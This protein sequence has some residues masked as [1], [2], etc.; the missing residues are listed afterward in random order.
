MTISTSFGVLAR[1]M[2]E[3]REQ[4]EGGDG[5]ELHHIVPELW[6]Y[7]ERLAEEMDRAALARMGIN[8][9]NSP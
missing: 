6:K 1:E 2:R 7:V 4:L 8:A 3:R 9:T 5:T